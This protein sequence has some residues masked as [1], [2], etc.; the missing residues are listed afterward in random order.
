MLAATHLGVPTVIHEGNAVIG[1]ANLFLAR[2]VDAIAKGFADLGGLKPGL[3]G[4]TFLTGDPVRP[5]VIEAAK[6]PFPD[7]SGGKLRPRHR[8]LAGR[9]DHVG[10]RPR[11][12]RTA[13]P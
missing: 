2:R 9:A 3:A 7:F 8:R 13:V 6:I 12:D 10:H 5:M 4:K 1:K 11:R